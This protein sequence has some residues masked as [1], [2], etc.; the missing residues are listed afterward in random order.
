[1]LMTSWIAYT[2]FI[3]MAYECNLRAYLIKVDYEEFIDSDYD[4][5]RSGRALYL[6]HNTAQLEFFLE[7]PIA[8]QRDLG[9]L[10]LEEDRIY[11]CSQAACPSI[12]EINT[13]LD[14]G[15]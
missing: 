7:S 2:T 1:M 5:W 9:L 11:H 15:E 8:H 13:I 4:M 3:M 10:A 6:P 12:E 14:S